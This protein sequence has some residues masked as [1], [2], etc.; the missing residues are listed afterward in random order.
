MASVKI[1]GRECATGSWLEYGRAVTGGGEDPAE[2]LEATPV[3]ALARETCDRLEQA[4]EEHLAGALA[5]GGAVICTLDVDI[6]EVRAAPT[7][8]ALATL[9][10]ALRDFV[11]CCARQ[12]GRV[13]GGAANVPLGSLVK[14]PISEVYTSPQRMEREIW[15]SLQEIDALTKEIDDAR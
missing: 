12:Q 5:R 13:A 7:A 1:G 10:D 11:R 3:A 15:G 8:D 2:V 14:A 6:A 4:L 9:A